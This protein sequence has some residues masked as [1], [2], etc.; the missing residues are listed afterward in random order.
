MSRCQPPF[1]PAALTLR[2]PWWH[3][4]SMQVRAHRRC[5]F[6][7]WSRCLLFVAVFGCRFEAGGTNQTGAIVGQ[8]SLGGQSQAGDAATGSV[9]ANGGVT[10]SGVTTDGGVTA[11]GVPT[12]G[13]VTAGGVT[14]GGVPTDGGV[15]TNG[16][17]GSGGIPQIVAGSTATTSGGVGQV[18]TTGQAGRSSCSSD[19]DCSSAARHC[20]SGLGQ[21]VACLG[22]S[23][24]PAG[25]NCENDACLP[26]R[27]CTVAEDCPSSMPKCN[28]AVGICERCLFD[29]DCSASQACIDNR[30]VSFVACVNSLNCPGMLVCDQTVSRCVECRSDADCGS[31]ATKVCRGATCHPRCTSDANCAA[32]TPKCDVPAGACVACVSATDCRSDE[33]CSQGTCVIDRCSAGESRCSTATVVSICNAIGSGYDNPSACPTGQVCSASLGHASCT[34][35][36]VAGSGGTAGAAGQAGR[37][38]QGG[39]AGA[40]TIPLGGVAGSGDAN[41]GGRQGGGGSN[42]AGSSGDGGTVG[43]GGSNAAGSSGDGGT[44]GAAGTTSVVCAV[45][46]DPCSSIPQFTGTQIV[47]GSGDEFCAVPSFELNFANAATFVEFN[48]NYGP[49]RYPERAI[50]RV[51]WST[52]HVHVLVRVLDPYVIRASAIDYIWGADSVEVM[53]SSQSNLTGSTANDASAMHIIAAPWQGSTTGMAAAARTTGTTTTHQQ[54]PDGQFAVATDS[55]GYTVE[56]MVPWT[57]IAKVSAASRVRF[58]LALN[59]AEEGITTGA[60][61]RDAQAIYY[62]PANPPAISPCGIDV[63]PYCDDRI[64]CPTNLN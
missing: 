8:S 61:V 55:D 21:C 62:Y 54:L 22:D 16:G 28:V 56:L 10:A 32:P 60:N 7:H 52:T 53:I 15:P 57:G 35:I 27:G 46:A 4:W 29:A 23:D 24:C 9:L 45:G 48:G 2:D 13:G 47:D 1:E 39:A 63:E 58:E 40:A 38:G 59:V 14:A 37:A 42:A 36:G 34:P 30:C 20:L 5:S 19:S 17:V 44:V 26:R 50:A 64:W 18:D 43:G 31:E 6:D 11:G 12:D 51:A 25:S 49:S 41:Q 3:R 33:F